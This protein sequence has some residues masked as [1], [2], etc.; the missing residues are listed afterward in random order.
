MAQRIR[1]IPT[2]NQDQVQ[3]LQ[4]FGGFKVV[5]NPSNKQFDIMDRQGFVVKTGSVSGGTHKLKIAA[6]KALE[7]LGVVFESESRRVD[8]EEV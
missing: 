4:T 1:Y 6:K 3:S 5:L 8:N 7:S 2:G